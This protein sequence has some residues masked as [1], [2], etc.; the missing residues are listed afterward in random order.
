MANV[1]FIGK[2]NRHKDP[3]KIR[4]TA[5][6]HIDNRKAKNGDAAAAYRVRE[7]KRARQKIAR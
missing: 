1:M 3:N 7:R 5:K 6:R 2:K 4:E